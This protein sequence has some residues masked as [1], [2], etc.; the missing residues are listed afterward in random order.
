LE[1]AGKRVALAS[2]FVVA[3]ANY[4]DRTS[5]AVLQVPIKTELGLSDARLGLLTGLCF[6]A[7]YTLLSIPA[8][9]I[10]DRHNRKHLILAALVVWSLMTALTGL[11]RGFWSLAALRMGVAIGEACC[12]PSAYALIADYFPLRERGR[13]TALFGVA[14]PL[15][16]MLG[17]GGAG[18]LTA[19][20]GWRGAFAALGGAGLI[21]A[22]VL[23]ATLREPPRDGMDAGRPAPTSLR[24]SLVGLWR[25]RPYRYIALG[26]SA[27]AV[28]VQTI[29]TWST[30]FYVR[31]HHLPL[32][33]ASLAVG[34]MVGLGGMG[35]MLLG[36]ALADRLSRRAAAWYVRVPAIAC[37]TLFPAALVQLLAPDLRVSMGFGAIVALTLNVFLAPTYA[38]TQSLVAPPIRALAS[39]VIV[40]ATAVVGGTI[41]PFMTGWLADTLAAQP[42]IGAT[43]IRYAMATTLASA[44]AAAGLY[45][46]A[47]KHL[48]L[49]ET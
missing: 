9:R 25:L 43:A 31:V 41:G 1:G 17:L 29:V 11:A 21:L 24:A 15:G 4:V 23:L 44:L 40:A 47:T 3:L 37:A 7:P 13:A 39:G 28:A 33:T 8:A 2:L 49:R 36:G 14:F 16:A 20:F 12:L 5:L 48:Q 10:A 27:Q 45:G 26:A 35:G 34:L 46:L 32:K 6:I 42:A 18:W 19:P 22:P 38:I 30:P